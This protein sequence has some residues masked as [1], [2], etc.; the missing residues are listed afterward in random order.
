MHQA[1]VVLRRETRPGDNAVPR[2]GAKSTSD[3]PRRPDRGTRPHP[4]RALRG[5]WTAAA[6]PSDTTLARMAGAR[7]SS[8]RHRRFDRA[9]R[10]P[11]DSRG[12]AEARRE[13]GRRAAS[14]GDRPCNSPE[15][16]RRRLRSAATARHSGSYD[17]RPP[18]FVCGNAHSRLGLKSLPEDGQCPW[19]QS[20]LC[21][22]SSATRIRAPGDR[23]H[24]NHGRVDDLS[25]VVA[26]WHR[27][28]GSAG[29]RR[30]WC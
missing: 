24:G 7:A 8:Q 5:P 26:G 25:R 6:S 18:C 19:E 16:H 17:K 20:A 22:S 15:H 21:S 23:Q 12:Y 1:F 27:A 14:R 9:W 2:D 3:Y 11:R 28:D 29:A 10:K 30:R 13:V 4:P